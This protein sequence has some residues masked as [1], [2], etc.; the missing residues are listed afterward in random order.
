[1]FITMY[2]QSGHLS[3]H[4]C[5]YQPLHQVENWSISGIG[6]NFGEGVCEDDLVY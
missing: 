5:D 2:G 3:T 1:M 6:A 4:T